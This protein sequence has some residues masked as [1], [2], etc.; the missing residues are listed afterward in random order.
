MY[1]EL[2]LDNSKSDA[3]DD[4]GDRLINLFKGLRKDIEDQKKALILERKERK[5]DRE[6]IARLDETL[7][8]ERKERK[9]ETAR[10]NRLLILEQEEHK[11]ENGSLREEAARLKVTLTKEREERQADV[12]R[13]EGTIEDR[14]TELEQWRESLELYKVDLAKAKAQQKD[15][16]ETISVV[17]TRSTTLSLAYAF[18]FSSLP[19]LSQIGANQPPHSVGL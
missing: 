14:A 18:S 7:I 8:L 13:L 15:D 3:E 1:L 12:A 17:R 10:L 6:K 4:R 5:M 2:L 16:M 9:E 19:A 11:V